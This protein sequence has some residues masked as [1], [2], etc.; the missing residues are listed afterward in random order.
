MK[1]VSGIP[2]FFL[3]LGFLAFPLGAQNR[4]PGFLPGNSGSGMRLLYAV[5]SP[6]GRQIAAAY[7]RAIVLLDA[8]SGNIQNAIPREPF[9]IEKGLVYSS[10]GRHLA[11]IDDSIIKLVSSE[12]GR[13]WKTLPGFLVNGMA[14]SPSGM[15]LAASSGRNIYRYHLYGPDYMDR[16]NTAVLDPFPDAQDPNWRSIGE[17]GLVT[18][19]LMAWTPPAMGSVFYGPDDKRLFVQ[20]NYASL[21]V[22]NPET[23]EKIISTPEDRNPWGTPPLTDPAYNFRTGQYAFKS[24]DCIVIVKAES[25]RELRRISDDSYPLAFS[26][27]GGLLV[28]GSGSGRDAV[29][30]HVLKVWDLRSG[31]LIRTINQDGVLSVSYSPDGTKILIASGDN[32]LHILSARSYAETARFPVLLSLSLPP[33][34]PRV[35]DLSLG[36]EDIRVEPD[37]QGGYHLYIRQK[38][39][40][41]SVLLTDPSREYAYRA[42]TRNPVNG[43]EIRYLDG[44]ILRD[45]RVPY[46]IIDSTPEA[47]S[48]FGCA[49]HLYIPQ[50]VTFGPLGVTCNS[51]AVTGNT[52]LT[53]RTFTTKYA[54][55]IN[56]AYHDTVLSITSLSEIQKGREMMKK[57]I[58]DIENMSDEEFLRQLSR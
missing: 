7:D 45:P 2:A 9:P 24:E 28:S 22:L 1:Q 43:S 23:G 39:D 46:S 48:Q 47:D 16:G 3:L 50:V 6:N 53:L 58:R 20:S 36:V 42:F 33:P 44:K 4:A 52:V 10:D 38:P 19:T 49:L 40:I 29:D 12:T 27:D 25:C 55:Y 34:P 54:D 15:Y 30:N 21:V 31:R 5:Y 18:T 17:D 35:P 57:A 26:P 41:A 32:T 37:N 8:A 11:Y 13:L 51:V 14:F 56:A